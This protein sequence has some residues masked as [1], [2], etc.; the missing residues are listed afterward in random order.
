[1]LGKKEGRWGLCEYFLKDEYVGRS[2]HN[3]GE[4]NPDETEKIIELATLGGG[5]CMD[6]GANI[7]CITQALIAKGFHVTAYEPQ[8]EVYNVLVKNI[9]HAMKVG[10]GSAMGYNLAIGS[11]SGTVKMPKIHYSEK[12]NI[13]G[14][15]I[16][17]KSP[18]GSYDVPVWPIDADLYK[19]RIGFIKIDVEGYELEV[20]RGATN[21]IKAHKPILYIE[22]DRREKSAALRAYI[23]ELGYTI[24]EH[25]PT[26]YREENFFGLKKN[27]WSRNYASHNIICRP[28][29]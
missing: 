3:Y 16:G 11:T 25:Q 5:S 18:L 24:E 15:G 27:I 22:D 29:Y 19:A 4:Y 7:G 12:N 14:L 26:L 9:E 23:S 28:C 1:M 17:T 2:I 8:P 10:P 13:G 20:L 21:T 6:I